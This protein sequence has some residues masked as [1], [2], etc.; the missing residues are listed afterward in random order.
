MDAGANIGAEVIELS[1]DVTLVIR[2]Q[3]A[4]RMR[5]IAFAIADI[6]Q[7]VEETARLAPAELIMILSADDAV[8]NAVFTLADVGAAPP[9]IPRRRGRGCNHARRRRRRRAG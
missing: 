2:P 4:A 1:L 6:G 5:H 3:I 7:A 8:V 9:F